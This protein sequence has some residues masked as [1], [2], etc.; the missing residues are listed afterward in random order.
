MMSWFMQIISWSIIWY[1]IIT[2]VVEQTSENWQ[3][4]I[5]ITWMIMIESEIKWA[6]HRDK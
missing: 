5:Q 6:H 2:M 1:E 4:L 3:P